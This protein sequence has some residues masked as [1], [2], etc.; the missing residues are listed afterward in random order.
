MKPNRY[1]ALLMILLFMT[2]LACSLTDRLIE[3]VGEL[4][5]RA[6]TIVVEQAPDLQLPEPPAVQPPELSDSQTPEVFRQ[7]TLVEGLASLD[8][9]SSVFTLNIQGERGGQPM[10]QQIRIE[11]QVVRDQ[12]G[13]RLLMEVTGSR[14]PTQL[15]EII[16]VSNQSFISGI[17]GLD[18]QCIASID[19][20][21]DPFINYGGFRVENVLGNFQSAQLLQSGE[22]INGIRSD[23]YQVNQADIGLGMIFQSGDLWIAQEAGYVVRYTG[24]AEVTRQ[25]FL[26]DG[27]VDQGTA[28][29]E[30]NLRDINGLSAVSVPQACLEAAQRQ[31]DIPVPTDT[32]D[33]TSF[34]G[35]ITFRSAEAVEQ[36]AEFYR[37]ELPARGWQISESLTTET[38]VIIAAAKAEQVIQVLITSGDDGSQVMITSQE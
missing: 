15:F 7:G 29:W 30:Y 24:Q 14:T 6:A 23:R 33:L 28:H 35:M 5:E 16:Q 2:G 20:S 11:E 10:D 27:P 31:A 3:Q 37:Q 9:Y 12:N 18:G 36:I 13:Q 19:N 17:E 8:S 4:P 38:A 25:S 21:A 22:M 1:I 26:I 34:A 32:I